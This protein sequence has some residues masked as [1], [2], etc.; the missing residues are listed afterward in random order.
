MIVCPNCGEENPARFRLC[1]YCGTAL[2]PALPTTEL[3]KTVTIVFSD[4]KGSTQ[5]GEKLDPEAVREVEARYF[6]AMRTPLLAHGGTLEKYI[7]DAIMA[8]FGF[9]KVREDDA[10]RAVRAAH[11]MQRALAALNVELEREYGVTLANRTGVNTGP[12]VANADPNANQQIVTGDTVNTAARLEQSAPAQEVLI[13]ELTYQLTRDQIEVEQVD[14]LE[15]KGKAEKVPA[16][17]LLGL[18]SA[19]PT[20]REQGRGAPTPFVGRSGELGRLTE[21]LDEVEDFRVCRIRLVVGD[22]G[23]GK[24]RLIRQFRERVGER[25]MILRGRCLPYGDGITFWPLV[26]IV[27]DAAGIEPEDAPEIAIERIVALV[28]GAGGD[29]EEGAGIVDRVAAAIG[30]STARFP[31]AE[32]FWGARKLLERL[33]RSRPLVLAIDDIHSA[34]PTFLEFLDHLVG[35]VRGAPILIVCGARLEL[36]EAHAEWWDAQSANRLLLRPL[37]EAETGRIIGSLLPDGEVDEAVLGRI[38][39]AA[40]GNPLFVEQVVS[41]LLDA[42]SLRRVEHRWM[43]SGAVTELDVPPS[44]SALLAARLDHISREERAVVEPASVIGLTFPT[45][46]VSEMVPDVIRASVGGH[47]QTLARKRFVRPEASDDEDAYRFA[48]LL[49]RDTAY[50]SLLKRARATM[51]ERFVVWAERVNRERGRETE[52]E[53][54]L[55]YH[56]EQ[57]FRYR[58]ELGRLDDEG[59]AIGARAAQKLASA[60]RRALGRGDATAA[61]SLLRR[62]AAVLDADDPIRLAILSD[63]VDAL[64]ETGAFDETRAVLDDAEAA[65]ERLSDTRAA[66]IVMLERTGLALFASGSTPASGD[67]LLVGPEAAIRT[68]EALGD[69]GGLARAWAVLMLIHGTAGRWDRCAEAA[70][71]MAHHAR[72]AGD[73]RRAGGGAMGYA[74]SALHGRTPVLEAI[75]RCQALVDETSGNRKAEGIILGVLGL[76]HAMRGDFDRARRLAKRGRE[77]LADLGASV[78]AVSTSIE[79]ARIEA[80]AGDWTAAEALLRSDH[81]A[82]AALDERYFR[83]TIA[84]G[85]GEALC[86]L[87]RYDEAATFCD[88]AVELADPEDSYTQVAWRLVRAKILSAAGDLT[89]AESVVHEAVAAAAATTDIE[90][91]AD[92]LSDL[93]AILTQA[94]RRETAGPPLREALAFY[95]EKGDL[96]SAARVTARLAELPAG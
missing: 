24:S 41:M 20:E 86:Q 79:G 29:G 28:G 64:V 61:A 91:H 37:G 85:L 92:A 23:V 43:A 83:A 88:A 27:R 5:L 8:V 75:E 9:P 48:N 90:Q 57:A 78:T 4:L 32:L 68:F 60:G 71:A 80:L 62:A 18:R 1:G 7:G 26:E 51:H 87:G 31:V 21:G 76:L 19:S 15:L 73:V 72:I 3:R 81:D 17:R 95:E 10:L 69:D 47:L 53:E 55:G 6:E 34:E 11:G 2:A 50:G 13:G 33:A 45:E 25:A 52:F 74:A 22:A 46:A 65:A 12:V 39:G 93:A 94:G 67:E 40:E 56:L 36:Q 14:P 66:A 42:G 35:S 30:L 84:A 77:I 96:V 59:R 49:V 54:I 58:A 70:I 44:I 89:G 38:V 16:Y 82:L 63:L